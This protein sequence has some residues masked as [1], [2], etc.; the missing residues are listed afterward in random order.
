MKK[1]SLLF[2]L[3]FTSVVLSAQEIVSTQ[4]NSYSMG[5]ITVDY[6]IGELIIDTGTDGNYDITQ[7]FHQTNLQVLGLEDYDSHYEV[8]VYPVPLRAI[9]NIKTNKLKNVSF[10]IYDML[11][12]FIMKGRLSGESTPIQVSQL[13][14]GSYFLTLNSQNQTLKTFKLVKNF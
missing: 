11:G 9:L 8:T 14:I 12:K 2:L 1:N 4:G 13:A 7:G 3:F 6:T 5:N 10:E